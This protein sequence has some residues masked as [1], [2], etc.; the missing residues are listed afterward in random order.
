LY[1]PR[2]WPLKSNCVEYTATIDART[3]DHVADVR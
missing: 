2:F 1:F 3:D